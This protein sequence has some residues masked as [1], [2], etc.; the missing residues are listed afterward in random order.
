MILYVT[1]YQDIQEKV[2]NSIREAFGV[3]GH[4]SI[5]DEHRLPL[6]SALIEEIQ[7]HSPAITIGLPQ[8]TEEDINVR[9]YNIPK[10]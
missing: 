6:I 1:E 4:I 7:R 2:H 10:G 8:C 5:K 3:D 9:G